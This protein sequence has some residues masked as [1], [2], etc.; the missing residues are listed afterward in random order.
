[1]ASISSFVLGVDV[2]Y[3]M[4]K[5][6]NTMKNYDSK[7]WENNFGFFNGIIVK[8]ILNPRNSFLK[9]NW[10]SQNLSTIYHLENFNK[11]ETDY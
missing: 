11:Q 3:D 2:K 6:G 4:N 10:Y 9:N 5:I 8:S 7:I 1:M